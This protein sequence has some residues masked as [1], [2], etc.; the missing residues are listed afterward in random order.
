MKKNIV[1]LVLGCLMVLLLLSSCGIPQEEHDAVLAERDA[2]QTEVESLQSDLSKVEGQ[3]E[4]VESDLA[5]VQAK[6][7]GLQAQLEIE[8]AKVTELSKKIRLTIHEDLLPTTEEMMGWIEHIYQQGVRR[9]GYTADQWAEQWAYEE[10]VALGLKDVRL[11]PVEVLQ[12]EDQS[13]TLTY[14]LESDPQ[15]TFS[16]P[17]F[18]IPY[19]A[20]TDGLEGPLS[21]VEESEGRI[22]VKDIS[23]IVLPQTAMTVLASR[24]YDPD[25]EFKTVSQVVPFSTDFMEVMKSA[26]DAG[27]SAFIGVL[28]GFPWETYQYYV[29]Y[30][31]IRRPIPGIYISKSDGEQLKELMGQGPVQAKIVS[32]SEIETVTTHNV[33]GTL[34][35]VSDEWIVIGSHHDGPWAS[36]VEDASGIAMVLAQAKYWSQIPQEERPHNLLFLLNSGHMA[37]GMGCQAF[38]KN[39]AELLE[40]TV[41]EIHLEHT[42]RE[43]RVEDGRL[44]PTDRP[45]IRWWWT[46]E[47]TEL[48]DV[49]EDAI[50][51]EDLRRSLLLP[52]EALGEMPLTD[53]AYFYPAG[54]PLVQY[55][56]APMYLFDPQD[57][58]DMIHQDSLVSVTRATIRIINGMQNRSASE[59]RA[60]VRE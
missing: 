21:M 60:A 59:L 55:L 58:P 20:S 14:W 52:P 53:G 56:T 39:N 6:V 41:L 50:Q 16:P 34:P 36:A 23:L 51:A 26:I 44:I 33:I 43:C 31:A 13:C 28:T 15:S 7:G 12:W 17:C 4:T 3:I 30:D 24:Y 47:I 45:E 18:A 10:F 9:P 27:A 49:V 54:V 29:P 40:Q 22:A 1:C 25:G 37:N 19:S 32:K 42:A 57:T 48:E 8:R 35:G 2:A 5:E 38:V 11:E 46:S